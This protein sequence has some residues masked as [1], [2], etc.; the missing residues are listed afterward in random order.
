MIPRLLLLCAC[1]VC[2]SAQAQPITVPAAVQQAFA[3]DFAGAKTKGWEMD[4]QLYEVEFAHN[5]QRLE[6]L[7]DAQ[8]AL[9]ATEQGIGKKA[10]PAAVLAT[11]GGTPY[12]GWKNAEYEKVTLPNGTTQYEI[13]VKQGKETMSLLFD[14]EGKLVKTQKE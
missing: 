3:K 8:G 4:G 5:G 6:A 12:A 14:A 2:L 10:V 11:F 9:Q 7:Y 13:E 1:A